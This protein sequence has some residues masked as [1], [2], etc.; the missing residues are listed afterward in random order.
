MSSVYKVSANRGSLKAFWSLVTL[1]LLKPYK[2]PY[3]CFRLNTCNITFGKQF[4][5]IYNVMLFFSHEIA[6]QNLEKVQKAQKSF[7]EPSEV[8]MKKTAPL[9]LYFICLEFNLFLFSSKSHPISPD[10]VFFHLIRKTKSCNKSLIR[11]SKTT[12]L[13]YNK[14][15]TAQVRSKIAKGL[16]SVKVF[17]STVPKNPKV[18]PNWDAW[19]FFIHSVA[20][21]QNN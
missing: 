1:Y 10:H 8:S 7:T 2:I 19:R 5:S 17:F 14:P 6:I 16:Q 11:T 13:R 9:S 18:G 3:R 20:N 15:G 21:H 12:G 4:D